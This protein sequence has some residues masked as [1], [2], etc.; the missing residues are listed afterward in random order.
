MT[1]PATPDAPRGYALV[2]VSCLAAL[3]AAWLLLTA[4]AFQDGALIGPQR[5]A[6]DDVDAWAYDFEAYLNAARRLG[7]TGS[8]YQAETL[9]GPYRPGP[10]GL[11]MYAPP[12]GVSLLPLAD[13]ALSDAAVVWWAIRFAALVAACALMPTRLTVRLGAFV[14]AASSAAVMH[15]LTIGNVS[16]LLLLPLAAAWRWLDRPAG[17]VAQ[18]FAI[19]IRP[20]LGIVIIWQ[21]LRR[22]WTAVLWTLGAGTGLAILTL[23]IVGVEGYRDYLTVLGNLSGATGVK[24]NLDLSSTTLTLGGSEA[25]AQVALFAGYAIAIGAVL[26][27]LRRDREVGFIVSVTA[28]LLLAP[29]LWGH[30]LAMLVLPAAFLAE[31]GRPIA[32][33]LPLLAWLPGEWAPFVVILGTLLPFWAPGIPPQAEGGNGPRPVREP[34]GSPRE[35]LG[36][37]LGG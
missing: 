26:L 17:S 32:I 33:L 13:V 27:S 4:V 37:P 21:L 34:G 15:D 8:L 35:A 20:M 19:A 1:R 22:R 6:G 5:F 12:L 11:Y 2:A 25:L 14:V 29:L 28:S 7:D 16:V 31:R 30:Y 18:A 9:G 36:S 23:P 24:Y 10:F 3:A